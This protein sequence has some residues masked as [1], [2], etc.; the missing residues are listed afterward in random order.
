MYWVKSHNISAHL[1]QVD[2][3]RMVS[4][5]KCQRIQMRRENYFQGFSFLFLFFKTISEQNVHYLL[6][7]R[8]LLIILLFS[9]PVFVCSSVVK[10]KKKLSYV[11]MYIRTYAN[12]YQAES[13]KENII[14]TYLCTLFEYKRKYRMSLDY[15]FQ[16]YR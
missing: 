10:T 5:P 4:D 14:G 13:K 16:Y 3:L 6:E 15:E 1:H 9:V 7:L 12:S 2:H 11:R 8:T